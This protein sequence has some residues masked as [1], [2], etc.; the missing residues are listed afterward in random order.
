MILRLR[1]MSTGNLQRRRNIMRSATR[2]LTDLMFLGAAV[3]LVVCFTRL[4]GAQS[5]G[6]NAVYSASGSCNPQ[7]QGSAA[8][9]D[10]S[11]FLG[12]GQTQGSDLCD[13]IYKILSGRTGITYP[14]NGAVVDARG[15]NSTNSSLTCAKGTPWFENGTGSI[16]VPSTILL[17]A[18]GGGSN[19]TPIIIST[20]WTLPPNT[21]VIGQGDNIGS[22]TTIQAKANSFGTNTPMIQFGTSSCMP[23][24][25]ASTCPG[26]AVENL[27][28]DGQ[29]QAINGITNVYSG[30][31][32]YVDHVSLYQILGTGLLVSAAFSGPALLFHAHSF[33]VPHPYPHPLRRGWARGSQVARPPLVGQSPA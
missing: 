30:N 19:F 9:I 2:P 33:G 17:P 4:A 22:G 15:V 32:S 7:C 8:F 1:N 21:H 13:V 12:N 3:V 18:T 6:Q 28:L 27:V 10:A 26:M 11:V 25:S 24:G 29:G 14:P 31:N 20:T 5:Q 16:S 23:P